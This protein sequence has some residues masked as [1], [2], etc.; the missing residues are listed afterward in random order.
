MT[1][2]SLSFAAADYPRIRGVVD[3]SGPPAGITLRYLRLTP[4]EMF[5]RML[6]HAEFDVSELSMSAYVAGLS[7]GDARFIALPVFTL[8][9]FRHSA[10][11]VN[12][13]AG[14]DRPEDLRGRRIGVPEY[15]MTACLY[16]RGMLSDEYAVR[17]D[18][19]NWLQ[20]GL[21][22][23]GGEERVHL[24][25][26]ESI[27]LEA[28]PADRCLDD[29]LQDGEIDALI[30]PLAPNSFLAGHPDVRRL[31]PDARATELAYYQ[32][33]GVFPIMHV[34]VMRRS[35]H[36]DQPWIAGSLQSSFER[37]KRRHLEELKT[38]PAEAYTVPFFQSE[39]ESTIEHF[40]TDFWP[41]GI[42]RNQ[43]TL[44]AALRYSHEQGL[45]ARKVELDE[46]F[47]PSAVDHYV[48]TYES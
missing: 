43:A 24:D 30:T 40:G 6:R 42:A 31:F 12:A 20:G 19:V 9:A 13:R 11:F 33:T 48:D 32:R 27:S 16:A 47:A 21:H 3:G 35:L 15:H 38:H 17:A 4:Q 7:R 29:M 46:M 36:Q 8:R 26:P 2:L 5:W 34:V 45:S 25:L 39:L 18:D 22:R 37:A 1:P 41:Y 14:I 28:I 23:P 44:Q 10:I